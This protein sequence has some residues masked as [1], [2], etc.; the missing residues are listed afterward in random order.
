MGSKRNKQLY[1]Q[2]HGKL[3]VVDKVTQ[4]H[5]KS[6]YD[7]TWL[8]TCECGNFTLAKTGDLVRGRKRNCGCERGKK[9]RYDLSDRLFGDLTAIVNAYTPAGQLGWNCQCTCGNFKVVT[10]ANLLRGRTTDCGCKM[11]ERRK[12][13]AKNV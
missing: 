13:K 12:R 10:T 5:L 11:K 6:K 4:P 3:Y 8:C 7:T 2:T 1:N 9:Q